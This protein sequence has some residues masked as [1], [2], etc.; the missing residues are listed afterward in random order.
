MAKTTTE[1]VKE[2]RERTAEDFERLQLRLAAGSK[3]KLEKIA[4]RHGLR[5]ITALLEA[6]AEKKLA[7]IEK[8]A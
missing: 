4:K 6:I 7:V 3:E 8:D 5:S 2:F 1:R